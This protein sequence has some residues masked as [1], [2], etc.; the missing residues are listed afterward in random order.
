MKGQ[1]EELHD[2]N[3]NIIREAY[4]NGVSLSGR[5]Y[6]KLVSNKVTE[7]VFTFRRQAAGWWTKFHV[8]VDF[9]G[10]LLVIWLTSVIS[11]VPC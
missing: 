2:D 5:L 1:I 9:H 11:C 8:E 10:F 6:W 4:K 3:I 7:R